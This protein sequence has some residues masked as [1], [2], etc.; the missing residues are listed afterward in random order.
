MTCFTSGYQ[1]RETMPGGPV[2]V[3][4]GGGKGRVASAPSLPKMAVYFLRFDAP[5][6]D[7]SRPRC[8]A[9]YYVGY[10]EDEHVPRR[11]KMHRTGVW[12]GLGGGHLCA[13]PTFQRRRGVGF[14]VVRVLW[15]LTRDDERRIKRSGHF[16]RYD[17]GVHRKLYLPP[18]LRERREHRPTL[19]YA[20]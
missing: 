1:I 13:L 3:P 6:G 4:V 9:R 16:E 17:P 5:A 12:D 14:R 10:A 2:A 15:G 18:W 19:V 7:P 8:M 11:I 20:A